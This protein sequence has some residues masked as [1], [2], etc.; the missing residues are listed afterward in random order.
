MTASPAL[1]N[2]GQLKLSRSCSH[3]HEPNRLLRTAGYAKTAGV[4]VLRSHG[5]GLFPTVDPSLE[6]SDQREFGAILERERAQL[7]YVIRTNFDAHALTFAAVAVD[8]RHHGAGATR[9]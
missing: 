6:L 5:I 2:G 8:H 9:T 3:W 7:E 1:L 4:A